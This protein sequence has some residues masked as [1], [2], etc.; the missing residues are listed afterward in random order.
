MVRSGSRITRDPV[1][2]LSWVYERT[3][4]RTIPAVGTRVPFQTPGTTSW[5]R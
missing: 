2:S 4:G 1:A 3:P 5:P